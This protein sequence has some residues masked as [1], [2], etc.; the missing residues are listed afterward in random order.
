MDMETRKIAFYLALIASLW[1]LC[2]L[3]IFNKM[4]RTTHTDQD[5]NYIPRKQLIKHQLQED[6]QIL[7]N[8]FENIRHTDMIHEEHTC[9]CTGTTTNYE[10]CYFSFDCKNFTGCKDCSGAT[11]QQKKDLKPIRVFHLLQN[12]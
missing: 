7:Q 10:E 11:G 4:E 3:L 1:G 6:V 5:G 8:N 2:I 9:I 12:C